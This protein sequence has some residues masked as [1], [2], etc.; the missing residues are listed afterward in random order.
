MEIAMADVDC[1]LHCGH[2]LEGIDRSLL[3]MVCV[4]SNPTAINVFNFFRVEKGSKVLESPEK[5][6]RGESGSPRD[7]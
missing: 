2:I 1:M 3:I 7:Q 5:L 4:G 6:V